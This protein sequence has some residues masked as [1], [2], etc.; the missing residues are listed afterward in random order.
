MTPPSYTSYNPSF[1]LI[2]F[3]IDINA[4]RKETKLVKE[5]IKIQ[6]EFSF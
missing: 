5:A 1:G 6:M 4:L 3:C 2:S